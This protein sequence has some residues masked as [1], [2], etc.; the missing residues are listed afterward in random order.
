VTPRGG[1]GALFPSDRRAFFRG[2]YDFF[3]KKALPLNSYKSGFSVAQIFF[4]VRFVVAV[5]VAVAHL[6]A[7]DVLA[8][9]ACP[10]GAVL[11][12]ML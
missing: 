12:P 2:I 7:E 6:S 3:Q 8:V 11:G 9:L 1:A 4:L 5:D 10:R